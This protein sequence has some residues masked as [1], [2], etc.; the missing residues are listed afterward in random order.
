[1]TRVMFNRMVT[2]EQKSRLTKDF[3]EVDFVFTDSV[4]DP[5]LLAS[6]GAQSD[7]LVGVESPDLLNAILSVP[8]QVRW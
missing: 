5:K 8:N 6:E 3:P 2:D 1:M 4:A 7:V